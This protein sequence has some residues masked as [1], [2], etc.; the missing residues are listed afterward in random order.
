MRI[1]V[2][3]HAM[4]Y[5]SEKHWKDSETRIEVKEVVQQIYRKASIPKT[6]KLFDWAQN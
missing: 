4:K 6:G 5:W 3:R 1:L 2:K